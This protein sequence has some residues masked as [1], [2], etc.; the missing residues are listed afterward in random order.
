MTNGYKDLGMVLHAALDQ[1]SAGKGK[2][3]HAQ[4]DTP[5]NRQPIM[6]IGRMV[7]HGFNT[8]QAIKKAQEAMRMEPEAAKRE[9]LGAINYLAAAYLL[10]EEKQES[11]GEKWVHLNC[12]AMV[13]R[14]LIKTI[15]TPRI[16][17]SRK[18]VS[19]IKVLS[20]K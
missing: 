19:L 12:L 11:E 6:E 13:N 16:L 17:K 5:F 3:R 8:G 7:G 1:A 2:E 4:G 14:H 18:F 15:Q 9:L 20:Y 10:I